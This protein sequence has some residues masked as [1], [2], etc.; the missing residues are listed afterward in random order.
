MK[1]DKRHDNPGRP[2]K[3]E[4]QKRTEAFSIRLT[5]AEKDALLAN[6]KAADHGPV[7]WVV[8]RCC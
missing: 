7:N 6:A 3:P 4:S 8:K 2:R 5:K 1:T